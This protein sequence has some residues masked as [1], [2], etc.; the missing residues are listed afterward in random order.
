MKTA[1]ANVHGWDPA[2]YA[3]HSAP[4]ASWARELV[5]RTALAGH[6]RVLDV[7]CGDGRITA[8][9]AR[10]V[11]GGF[12]VGVDSSPAMI[13]FARRN[14]R[15][16][17]FPNL[18][19]RIMD[20]RHLRLE[21]RVDLVFSSSVLHWVDDHPAFLE[22]AAASLNEGG[23]LLVSC[24]GKGNAQEVFLA[25]RS[26]MRLKQWRPFFRR[27][28]KPY[29]FHAPDDYRRWLPRSGFKAVKIG[30]A[31]KDAVYEGREGFA[32]WLRTTWLPY[33]E[34]VP[35]GD[36]E[37]FISAVVDHYLA[38]HPADRTGGRGRLRERL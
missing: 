22:G 19:F 24:G 37:E 35:A 7:G 4:Q 28:H 30:L 2:A 6:E 14:F 17:R 29:F 10:A 25:F 31:P 11:S 32:A 33:T 15:P 9:M 20:A 26:T 34:R 21:R 16:D 18:E 13:E 1:A 23:R 3:A 36:R 12:V 27:I 5:S 8:E 38:R